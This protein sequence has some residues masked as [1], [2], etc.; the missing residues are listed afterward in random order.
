MISVP[1]ITHLHL[2]RVRRAIEFEHYGHNSCVI[3]LLF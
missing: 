2:K 1:L 3:S